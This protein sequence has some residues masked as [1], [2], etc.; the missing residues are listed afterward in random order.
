M[1][2]EQKTLF[3]SD[4]APWQL[5]A[6]AEQLVAK[7]A[8]ASGPPGVLDYSVADSLRSAI[9]V[10]ARVRVPLGRG[11]R[12]VVG[13]CVGLENA[14][15]LKRALKPITEVVD[16]RSLISP[17]ML[18]LTEWMSDYYLCPLGQVLETVIPAGVRGS[19]GTRVMRL[20]SVPAKV[21]AQRGELKLTEK[22]ASIIDYLLAHDDPISSTQLASEIGCT[23][24][25]I[26]TL[27]RKGL[28]EIEMRR[29]ST[30]EAA[31][32]LQPTDEFLELNAQQERALAAILC[33]LREKLHETILLHGVTGSGKTEVYMHAIREVVSYGRQA[34]V[35]VPEISLTPQTVARFRGRFGNVAVLHSHL[36]DVERRGQWE[37]II[38]GSVSVV[39]GAR[40]AV[41]APTPQL[42][43]I[44]I[45][46][47]HES[48]FKQETAPRYH[49]REVARH[50]AMDERVPLVLGSATPSLDSYELSSL[51]EITLTELPKRV[52]DRPMPQVATI[53][54]RTEAHQ[55]S[56]R[57]A[58]SRPLHNAMDHALGEGGQV[59]LLLNRRGFSTHIQ[60]P[61][62]GE[63]VRCPNCAITLTHHKQVHQAVCHYCDF[64][65]AIPDRCGHCNF[66][67][68][69]FFGKGTQRLEEEVRTRFPDFEC[70]RMDTDSMQRRGSHESALSRFR[71]GEVQILLGTQM[72]AKGLDFPHVTLVGVINADTGLHLP[73]FRASER[74]F[75]LLTQ[76]A[77]RT[78][79][80]P[81]GGHVLIQTMQPE[82]PA[83]KAA[84]EHDFHAFAATELPARKMLGYPPFGSMVRCVIRC[85]DEE[86]GA[87]AT[88]QFANLV[89]T[90]AEEADVSVR[91]VGPAAAP[92][93]KLRGKYRF[94]FQVLGAVGAGMR[95]AV[96]IASSR[97]KAPSKVQWIV[98]IDPLDML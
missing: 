90:A 37:R 42:G 36:S 48:S 2:A 94:A 7:V 44:V 41:F 60:C 65:Q 81:R 30:A 51:G 40:S 26:T 20:V 80:G 27:L 16:S 56:S 57:G 38:S 66:A 25:P 69:R 85:S 62:C 61:S 53:D 87:A 89:R 63:P 54:L 9:Q 98:D 15:D 95:D 68:M 88:E 76:V 3:D 13:Y 33:A 93:A 18:R 29:M 70:L 6:A 64:R 84:V 4:A 97:F 11:N 77:G 67:G 32:E 82:H 45:D 35:L 92:I 39:V 21:G 10:G 46:E 91:I 19:V 83:I 23:Q 12:H 47:E 17:A 75:Q 71:E 79:R 5:D 22:Q 52:L 73:D 58:I 72:I 96:R 14:T 59:I 86:I 24:A 50:R 43:L 49:A 55:R 28:I 1:T 78:G 8:I 34:I 31:P 74:T